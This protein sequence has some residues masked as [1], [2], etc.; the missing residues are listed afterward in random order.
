MA[1]QTQDVSRPW[2]DGEL[3]DGVGLQ[4]GARVYAGALVEID[5]AGNVARAT[6]AAAK[7]YFGV[8]VTGGDNTGGAA[9]AVTITVRR[10]ATVLFEKTGTSVRGK[11][12]YVADDQTVTDVATAAS[13]V[14]QIVAPDEPSGGVWVDTSRVAV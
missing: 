1:N 4:A 7:V 2:R 3:V 11:A 14:G 12:A 13:K 8:A 5:A 6:K 9:A 10:G